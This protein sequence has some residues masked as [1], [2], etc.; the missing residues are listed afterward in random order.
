MKKLIS[1]MVLSAMVLLVGTSLNQAATTR[2]DRETASRG[3]AIDR[4]D[5]PAGTLD[6]PGLFNALKTWLLGNQDGRGS[7][8]QNDRNGT[9]QDGPDQSDMGVGGCRGV[10]GCGGWL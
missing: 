10:G 6:V 9:L 4:T 1:F 8:G 5:G 2:E 7:R 3:Q